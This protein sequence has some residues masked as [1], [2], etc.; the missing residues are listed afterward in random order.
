MEVISND[1]LNVNFFHTKS[2]VK[3]NDPTI[4]SFDPT[5][6]SFINTLTTFGS[7]FETCSTAMISNKKF[8]TGDLC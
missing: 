3:S 5:I 2:S 6:T 8:S 4:T 7:T 1:T